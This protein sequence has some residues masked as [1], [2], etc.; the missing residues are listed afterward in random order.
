ML[1]PH[2]FCTTGHNNPITGADLVLPSQ[3]GPLMDEATGGPRSGTAAAWQQQQDPQQQQ[4]QQQALYSAS[5]VSSPHG[6]V[7]LTSPRTGAYT[8]GVVSYTP[9]GGAGGYREGG[10]LGGSGK[11]GAQV[12]GLIAAW[13]CG[14]LVNGGHFTAHLGGCWVWSLSL[15]SLPAC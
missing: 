14:E 13:G 12:G 4:R 8:S 9:H 3:V 11:S 1:R 2:L 7:Y 6:S 10:K 15:R 5:G